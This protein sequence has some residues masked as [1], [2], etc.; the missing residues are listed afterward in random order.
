MGSSDRLLASNRRASTRR[1]VRG[2]AALAVA[3]MMAASLPSMMASAQSHGIA[4]A[5][6]VVKQQ[7]NALQVRMELQADCL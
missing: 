2:S 7:G 3:A 5:L 4:G 6:Y 1:A